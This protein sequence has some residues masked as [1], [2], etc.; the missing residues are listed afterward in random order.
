MTSP[1]AESPS[2]NGSLIRGAWINSLGTLASRVLGLVRDVTTA[3]LLG[4]SVSG[5]MDAFAIAF[6]IPNTFR[7][8]FGE[9]ALASG[10]LP[11]V[12]A[13]LEAD[14]RD[15]WRLTSV[16]LT[17]LAVIL[18]AVTLLGE[19]LI[20]LGW[21]AFSDAS[22]V[23]LLAGLSAVLLPYLLFICLAAQ[24]A[25]VL[26]AMSRFAVPALAPAV[27]NIC[28]IAGAL[29]AA[30]SA[31]DPASQVF[32]IALAVL[33]AGA[34]QFGTQAW[35]LRAAGF[36][37]DYH[38]A[39]ARDGIREVARSVLPMTLG[40]AVT[41]LNTLADSLIAWFFSAPAAGEA[42]IAWLGG[43]AYP[44]KTGAAASI[45]FGERLYE[46]PLAMIGIAVATAV[47]PLLSRHAARG[48]RPALSADLTLG[49]RLVAFLAV[50]A[51]VGLAILAE[52]ITRLL[53]EY[54]RFSADDAARAA[55]MVAC[56][57]AGVWAYCAVPVLVR[58]FYSVGDRA[59]PV[60]I[61]LAAVGCNLMLNLSLIWLL[62][63]SGL[64]VATSASAA[65]QTV[66][67]ATVFAKKHAALDG[68]TLGAVVVRSALAAAALACAAWAVWTAL[69]AAETFIARAIAV[70]GPLAAGLTAYLI[71]YRLLG[72]TELGLLFGKPPVS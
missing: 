28:W 47:Y 68:K 2:A 3:N 13:R 29:I 56:Y 21:A 26:Q 14:R 54:G 6:R 43:A 48:D 53:F 37:F 15:A 58:A 70:A 7:R 71:A 61:G 1:K 65:L 19:A 16:L 24:V 20:W 60:R 41:Q 31:A 17:W 62:A 9:G 12:A 72:G 8:L 32:V 44:M 22:G 35:A 55:R 23:G 57:S 40:M 4:M 64:A 34:L 66:W 52:P 5:A 39:S 10:F 69:P 11:V 51:S 30:R 46:F 38:W 49:L 67:L 27:L 42:S 18:A 50:P 45:Y 36:R 63:E 59:T 25:A 33:V